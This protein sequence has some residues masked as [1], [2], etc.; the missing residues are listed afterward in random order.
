MGHAEYPSPTPPL[1]GAEEG[2]A[3]SEQDTS[4]PHERGGSVHSK[5][6]TVLR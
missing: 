6:L 4:R 3:A 2:R 1:Y 5:S